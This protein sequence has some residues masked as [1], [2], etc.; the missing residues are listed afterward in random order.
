MRGSGLPAQP[1]ISSLLRRDRN[2]GLTSLNLMSCIVAIRIGYDWCS[3]KK[4]PSDKEFTRLR[5]DAAVAR[6]SWAYPSACRPAMIP[7]VTS[8]PRA[9]RVGS[10]AIDAIYPKAKI[11]LRGNI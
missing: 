10:N 5:L 11:C 3:L 9:W 6:S 8:T 7:S 4:S 1:G 2:S